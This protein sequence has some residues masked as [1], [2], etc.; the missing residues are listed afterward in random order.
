MPQNNNED[1]VNHILVNE[2]T[3][4]SIGLVPKWLDAP[5]ILVF[6]ETCRTARDMS[7][8]VRKNYALESAW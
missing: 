2:G 8:T 5:S 1:S 6:S 3:L 4:A 7:S